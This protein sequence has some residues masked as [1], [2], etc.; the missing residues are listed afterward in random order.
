[1]NKKLESIE[2]RPID[3]RPVDCHIFYDKITINPEEDDIDFEIKRLFGNVEYNVRR[4]LHYLKDTGSTKWGGIIRIL[5]P[6]DVYEVEIY[7]I[8]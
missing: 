7:I 1:M 8:M 5:K 2:I 6:M 3:R 4:V